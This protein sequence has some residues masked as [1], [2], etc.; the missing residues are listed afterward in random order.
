MYQGK[1]NYR[2]V[3]T[4]RRRKKY[5][6]DELYK[7]PKPQYKFN[8]KPINDNWNIN[9]RYQPNENIGSDLSLNNTSYTLWCHEIYEK[10]WSING[11][12]NLCTINNVSRFWRLFNN[13]HKLGMKFNQYFFMKNDITPIWEDI[14]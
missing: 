12:R 14:K 6:K 10:D 9:Q 5:R 1:S 7:I 2:K 4:N 11:Y 8:H 3:R 13:F